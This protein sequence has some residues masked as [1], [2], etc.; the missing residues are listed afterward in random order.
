M[1]ATF[2]SVEAEFQSREELMQSPLTAGAL[3]WE[4]VP[5]MVTDE[6]LLYGI[7]LESQRARRECQLFTHLP[8]ARGD[9]S[10]A[11]VKTSDIH[12]Y[13]LAGSFAEL[14]A[15]KVGGCLISAQFNYYDPGASLIPHNDGPIVEAETTAILSLVGDGTFS[16]LQDPDLGFN[17]ENSFVVGPGDGIVLPPIS[18]RQRGKYTSRK[19]AVRNTGSVVRISLV[20]ALA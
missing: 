20:A 4:F 17:D 2:Q 13:P 7:Y 16:V 3:G 15:K 8:V 14:I 6:T 9:V 10:V 5:G 1:T 12:R 11:L 18:A 19:H